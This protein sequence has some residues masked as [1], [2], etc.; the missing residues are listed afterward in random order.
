MD[1]S[2]VSIKNE[3]R[4]KVNDLLGAGSEVTQVMGALMAEAAQLSIHTGEQLGLSKEQA[5][6]EAMEMLSVCL[7]AILENREGS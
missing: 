4:Q 5:A 3:L 6:Q 1:D 7:E 2:L